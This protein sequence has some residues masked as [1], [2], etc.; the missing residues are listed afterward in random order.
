MRALAILACCLLL[1]APAGG[2]RAQS[3]QVSVEGQVHQPGARAL[4]PG[5]RLAEAVLAARPTADA[6]LLGAS[7]LRRQAHGEQLRMNAGLLYDLQALPASAATPRAVAERAA[8][9]A[10]WLEALPASGRVRTELD[11]RRLEIEP[12][13]NRLLA[14]GDRITYP[15]R[16]TTI[17]VVGAV[18]APCVLAHVPLR[19]AADYLRECAPDP[20]SSDRDTLFVVQP[21]GEVQV[22]GIA[23]WNRAA[24]QALAPGAIVYVPLAPRALQVLAPDFNRQLAEFLATQ[25]VAA[26][27]R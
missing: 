3:L 18:Q 9:L 13:S 1:S 22:L 17:Q 14:D 21:D 23:P 5:T 26:E 25:P 6:Y 2:V 27:A 12:A 7:L 11:P 8:V 20:A 24:P 19:D 4:P 10:A 15:P 16:P